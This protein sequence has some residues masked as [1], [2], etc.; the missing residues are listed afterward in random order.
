M[1]APITLDLKKFRKLPIIDVTLNGKPA[2][3][4]LDSGATFSVLNIKDQ[5]L[6]GF[7]TEEDT[8]NE[9]VGYGGQAQF[10]KVKW[11]EL[12]IGDVKLSGDFNAQD[13]SKIVGVIKSNEGITVNGIIGVNYFTSYGFILDFK[14]YKI[15]IHP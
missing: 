15:T 9:A 2:K 8:E 13:L 3:F 14:N 5:D 10:E 12:K 6:F 7:G 11:V 4:I 1:K